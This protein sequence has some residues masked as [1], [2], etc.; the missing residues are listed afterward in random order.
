MQNL[1]VDT[2]EWECCDAQPTTVMTYHHSQFGGAFNAY[3]NSCSFVCSYW[4]CACELI[5]DCEAY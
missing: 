4:E 1:A 2:M 3:C 5:H